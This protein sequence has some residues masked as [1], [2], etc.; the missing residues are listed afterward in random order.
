MQSTFPGI[1]ALKAPGPGA[2]GT[3]RP[4]KALKRLIYFSYPPLEGDNSSFVH[5][6]TKELTCL[7][8]SVNKTFRLSKPDRIHRFK[9]SFKKIP[10]KIFEV[11]F[12]V[13]VEDGEEEAV[14]LFTNNEILANIPCS[15]RRQGG[16]CYCGLRRPSAAIPRR[17][18]KNQQQLFPGPA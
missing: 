13:R 17:P 9:M 3:R 6:L 7:P 1:T 15:L 8:P 10:G 2:E 4:I 5:V 18:C 11:S 12:V 14:L 16:G